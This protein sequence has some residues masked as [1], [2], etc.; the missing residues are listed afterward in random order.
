MRMTARLF[1]SSCHLSG[2]SSVD[3]TSKGNK[4]LG[5]LE[6]LQGKG[7]KEKRRPFSVI[8]CSIPLPSK[9]HFKMGRRIE[10]MYQFS[11]EDVIFLNK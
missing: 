6:G 11:K 9:F 8:H 2:D 1:S 5:F 3:S 7:G 4:K 10:T